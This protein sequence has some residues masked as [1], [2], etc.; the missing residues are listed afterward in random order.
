M[1]ILL[2]TDSLGLPREDVA[3]D[4]TWTYLFIKKYKEHHEI[5]TFLRRSL[6]TDLIISMRKDIFEF[7]NPDMVIIQVGIV[8]CTRRALPKLGTAILSHLPFS[9]VIRKFISKN[10]YFLTKLYELHYVKPDRFRRNVKLIN[11]YANKN[12]KIIYL[13]IA[14][15]GEYISDKVYNIKKDIDF[16]NSIL[17]EESECN[18][19]VFLI[20][21]YKNKRVEEF[22]SKK[23]G[24]HLNELGNKLV[25]NELV[26][27]FESNILNKER[28]ETFSDI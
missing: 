3:I 23:D 6:T 17:L 13:K 9:E 16:Y 12:M 24:H 26:V 1:R 2:V 19:N 21:P 8:D 11:S 4:K 27:F 28:K 7:F 18:E 15:P 22:I 25:F 5:F 14:E 10:H 20:D